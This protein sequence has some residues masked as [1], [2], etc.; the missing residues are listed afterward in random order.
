MSARA[1]ARAGVA[2]AH[3]IAVRAL[4]RRPGAVGELGVDRGGVRRLVARA[5]AGCVR[6]VR[7]RCR[8]TAA[9]RL[10]EVVAVGLLRVRLVAAARLR[11]VEALGLLRVRLLA[12]TRVVDLAGRLCV[13]HRSREGQHHSCRERRSRGSRSHPSI[14]VRISI[15]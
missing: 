4:R 5:A 14:H 7:R 13:S 10:L 6:V 12:A 3:G 1:V 9:G 15:R 11:L 2:V 8:A